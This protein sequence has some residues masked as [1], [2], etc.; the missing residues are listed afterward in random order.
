MNNQSLYSPPFETAPPLC[1]EGRE[2]TARSH[3]DDPRVLLALQLLD[4]ALES[5][6]RDPYEE[7]IEL[8][9]KLLREAV[10]DGLK[11]KDIL[12][13]YYAA[14]EAKVER[15]MDC[16]TFNKKYKMNIKSSSYSDFF[17]KIVPNI[18]YE[19][20]EPY[21]DR[22]KNILT[23]TTTTN[24]FLDKMLSILSN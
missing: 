11:T 7:A 6:K 9:R 10:D 13:I 4:A 17:S 22:F 14:I 12:I 24:H 21:V 20:I 1:R 2:E 16:E 19:E 3:S 8:L 15:Q 23:R 5:N 18:Q